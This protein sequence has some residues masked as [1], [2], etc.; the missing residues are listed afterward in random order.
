MAR[1]SISVNDPEI[2][3]FLKG[4]DNV[5][6][7]VREGVRLLMSGDQ[8]RDLL[9]QILAEVTKRPVGTTTTVAGHPGDSDE[10]HRK[11]G[12]LGRW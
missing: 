7:T 6:A 5:S 1:I 3:A 4:Q 11:L 2:I 9:L 8:T 10:A 12:Q